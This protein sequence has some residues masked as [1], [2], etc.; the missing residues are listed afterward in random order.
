MAT[1]AQDSISKVE[2]DGRRPGVASRILPFFIFLCCGLLL[3]EP[4]FFAFNSASKPFQVATFIGIPLLFSA[5]AMLARRN[6]RFIDYL[7]ALN[8]FVM[9]SVGLLLMWLVDDFPRRWLNLDPK[10]PPGR[11]TIKVTDAVILLLT[12]IIVG[13]LLR[14]DFDSIYLRKGR[15]PLLGLAIGLAGFAIMAAF[16]FLE[17]QSMGISTSQLLGWTPWILSFVLANGFFEELMYRG[18]F[19]KKFEPLLGAFLSNFLIAFVFAIG[20][21][22]VTYSADVA[23]FVAITFALALIWGYL[24]QKT[25]SLWGSALFH[26]GADTLIIIGLFSGIKT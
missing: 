24:M 9:V 23:V 11:A 6:R 10:G 22:G 14:M 18:L 21:A 17:A 13:K 15:K 20:H 1:S 25:G 2:N 5:M 19:L 3:F 26:A 8:S 16:A 4:P 12:V 7:P